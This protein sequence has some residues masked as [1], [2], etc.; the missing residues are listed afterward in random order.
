VA[1]SKI[2]LTIHTLI[3]DR[4]PRFVYTYLTI[5]PGYTVFCA[6]KC[7]V[8]AEKFIRIILLYYLDLGLLRFAFRSIPF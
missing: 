1:V 3:C 4:D 6:L 2:Q 7:L 5:Q 8:Y